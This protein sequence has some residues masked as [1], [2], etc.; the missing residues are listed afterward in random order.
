MQ[1]IRKHLDNLET[2]LPNMS[3]AERE[4]EKEKLKQA[5]DALLG[6]Q[7]VE[8]HVHWTLH[9]WAWLKNKI[10]LGLRQ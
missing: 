2:A 4:R 3:D 1:E 9:L 7:A 5:L 8:H 6:N 10:G